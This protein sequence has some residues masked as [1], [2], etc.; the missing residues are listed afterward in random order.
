MIDYEDLHIEYYYLKREGESIRTAFRIWEEK[1]GSL[2]D[3]MEIV[4]RLLQFT[5]Q[6]QSSYENLLENCRELCD[7]MD[8]YDEL[9]E[10]HKDLR[11]DIIDSLNYHN[12]NNE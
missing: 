4:K 1:N 10:K 9:I 5:L 6:L 3:Y 2:K 8:E 12:I 7:K 11:K